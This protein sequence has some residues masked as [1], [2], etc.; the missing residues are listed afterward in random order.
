MIV[1]HGA[2][3]SSHPN[4]AK[5]TTTRREVLCR[6]VEVTRHPK[7]GLN[8]LGDY[9]FLDIPPEMEPAAFLHE[10]RGLDRE[11]LGLYDGKQWLCAPV[12]GEE[13]RIN[14]ISLESALGGFPQGL[15]LFHNHPH[16]GV[17]SRAD[18]E[19][20]WYI[21]ALSS[22]IIARCGAVV[23]IWPAGK[24]EIIKQKY[25]DMLLQIRDMFVM[26]EDRAALREI[27][28][29]FCVTHAAC[30]AFFTPGESPSSEPVNILMA[31][32]LSEVEKLVGGFSWQ[33]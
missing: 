5:S 13:S 20:A 3:N 30:I 12:L 1:N 19:F 4:H 24:I 26:V 32:S 8:R 15:H 25:E 21:C 33:C 27:G 6:R 29:D 17:L 10:I 2:Q 7:N 28:F 16:N 18:I 22:T 11:C 31:S 23:T 9:D 14:L